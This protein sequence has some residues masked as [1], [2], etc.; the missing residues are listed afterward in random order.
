ML[1]LDPQRLKN[2]LGKHLIYQGR[3]YQ[4]IDI[5][6]DHLV[7]CDASGEREIQANQYGNAGEYQPRTVSVAVRNVRGD[8]LNP[9]LPTLA[10]ALAAPE[11]GN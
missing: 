4:V 9:E 6:P 7:L 2:L 11:A 8:A 10:A 5:L 3:S 1:P